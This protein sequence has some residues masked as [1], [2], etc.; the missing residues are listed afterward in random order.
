MRMN[1]NRRSRLRSRSASIWSRTAGRACD[2]VIS[3]F[4]SSFVFGRN[5]CNE[6]CSPA[7]HLHRAPPS[8]SEL[9]APDCVTSRQSA[10]S[11]IGIAVPSGKGHA[12]PRATGP[13]TLRQAASTRAEHELRFAGMARRSLGAVRRNHSFR[14]QLAHSFKFHRRSVAQ[15]PCKCRHQ[16]CLGVNIRE[17]TWCEAPTDA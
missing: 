7:R 6:A 12:G 14:T 15:S 8:R 17:R 9:R 16:Y 13:A 3:R 11:S 5:A 2:G 1:S 10:A 4:R